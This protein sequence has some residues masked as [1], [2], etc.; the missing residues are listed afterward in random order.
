MPSYRLRIPCGVLAEENKLKIVATN[1]SANRYVY[2]DY[3]DKWNIKE[4]SAYFEAELK[5]AKDFVS[6]GLYR[7]VSLYTE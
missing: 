5:F 2:T 3:F 7:P 6:G 1:T 4:L